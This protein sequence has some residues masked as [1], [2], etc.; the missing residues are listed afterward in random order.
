[1]WPASTAR[2]GLGR[3]ERQDD[4]VVADRDHP[5]RIRADRRITD[6]A[7]RA[8]RLL[9]AAQPASRSRIGKL[10]SSP[11]AFARSGPSGKPDWLEF[12]SPFPSRSSRLA[13]GSK[14]GGFGLAIIPK[15]GPSL[16]SSPKGKISH[17]E[18]HSHDGFC[19]SARIR[20]RSCAP[21][22]RQV[23][24]SRSAAASSSTSSI[25]ARSSRRITT[26]TA[27][28]RSQ[29]SEGRA[30]LSNAQPPRRSGA[31]R[32]QPDRHVNTAGKSGR[33]QPGTGPPDRTAERAGR[34]W[35]RL[36]RFRGRSWRGPGTGLS[37][38]HPLPS[39]KSSPAP[40]WTGRRL[41]DS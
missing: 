37:R 12:A 28:T 2:P 36:L 20:R 9:A 35:W 39:S 21:R 31:L 5:E 7:G 19:R 24:A 1:M 23:P 11:L 6:V 29:D 14:R 34:D 15:V 13:R 30:G 10:A 22:F 16:G 38:H 8:V 18:A 26:T 41:F 25:A 17:A 32:R 33:P 27:P 3:P 4:L 40:A